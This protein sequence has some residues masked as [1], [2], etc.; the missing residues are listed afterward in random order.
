MNRLARIVLVIAVVSMLCVTAFGQPR[1]ER[2][3][4]S[5]GVAKSGGAYEIRESAAG[6]SV[7]RVTWEESGADSFYLWQGFVQINNIPV[8]FTA[9]A[10]D[11]YGTL[12]SEWNFLPLSATNPAYV[13]Y[14]AYGNLSG[15]AWKTSSNPIF[16]TGLTSLDTVWIDE[17]SE[18][19]YELNT[20]ASETPGFDNT[21]WRAKTSDAEYTGTVDYS[22]WLDVKDQNY[23]QQY[24]AEIDVVYSGSVVHDGVVN[25]VNWY[26]FGESF[27]DST[28]GYDLDEV[29]DWLTGIH[30]AQWADAGSHLE[31]PEFTVDGSEPWYT[32]NLREWEQLDKAIDKQITY[33]QPIPANMDAST[34]V[35]RGYS[36]MGVPLYPVEDHDLY[37][38]QYITRYSTA[39][40]FWPATTRGDQDL[41]L[42]DDFWYICE[43]DD[44]GWPGKYNSWWQISKYRGD[45]GAYAVYRGPEAEP[46]VEPFWPGHGY[47]LVQD[48]CDEVQIDVTG[49]KPNPSDWMEIPLTKWNGLPGYSG[50]FYNM[51]ANPFYKATGDLYDVLWKQAEIVHYNSGSIVETKSIAEAAT[52]SWIT[53]TI[54]TWRAN[55]YYQ[56]SGL[57][58][59]TNHDEPLRN[60]EGFWLQTGNGAP[61]GPGDSLVVR[62][63]TTIGP[64][65]RRVRP[66]PE[67][68]LAE[69]WR[70]NIGAYSEEAGQKDGN[71]Y[72]GFKEFVDE[73]QAENR[74]FVEKLPDFC[75]PAPH[76][77]LFF[78]DD[79]DGRF[80]EYFVGERS[81]QTIYNAILDCQSV[82][83]QKVAV[84]WNIESLPEGFAM[85]IEDPDHGI[86]MDMLTNNEYTFTSTM[87]K[88]KIRI[89]VTAPVAWVAKEGGDQSDLPREF[90]LAGPTPNPFNSASRIEF[91]IPESEA[92]PVKIEIFDITGR[93]VRTLMDR[94]L[95]A[96]F[97]D[98]TWRGVDNSG[99]EVASGTYFVRFSSP[100]RDENRRVSLIK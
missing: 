33:G 97:Y 58:G 32:V 75:Y 8:V 77:K 36:L 48:H 96:G 79:S 63:K 6:Q 73:A 50:M 47:W 93:K 66:T 71:N 89:I 31:F 7:S 26:Q 25:L 24:R 78:V 80:M 3:S 5:P 13:G 43:A 56:I 51:C 64:G 92:G 59:G 72:F 27:I 42:Y 44:G 53:S 65:S 34:V 28:A 4:F 86:F 88:H 95:D 14:R 39:P 98:V 38:A 35:W 94:D 52:A 21:R 23:F 46:Q 20:G 22:D 10:V 30:G 67:P 45:V 68:E 9:S 2:S 29:D 62:M 70:V 1:I 99:S 41:V 37:H 83:D 60:W 19:R 81:V 57:E 85:F 76:L 15:G 90:F 87:E 12:P 40:P 100:H 82:K 16:N 17:F 18:W 11:S 61:I 49:V 55:D 74:M 54:Q 69:A 84:R 91:G